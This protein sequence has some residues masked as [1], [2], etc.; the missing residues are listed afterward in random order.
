MRRLRRS[1]LP[2]LLLWSGVAFGAQ[3]EVEI[4]HDPIDC[5]PVDAF[6][7]VQSS[8][9]PPEDIQTAKFYFRSIEH[10]DYY[11]VELTLGTNGGRAIAPKAEPTTPGVSYY[12]ELVTRSFSAFRTEE[13]NVPVASGSECKRRDPGAAFYTGQNPDIAVGAT[14]LGATPLPPGFQ[15][16]GIARFLSA[17][18][19]SGEAGGGGGV[20]GK[21]LG[22]IAGIGGAGA[23]ALAL[24][25]GGSSETT[26]T[27]I[28]GVTTSSVSSTSTST[29]IGGVTS[30]T[31][32]AGG[33]GSSTS[34]ATT[35]VGGG[36]STTTSIPTTGPS[37]T[38]TTSPTTGPTTSP[39][40][41]PSTTPSTSPSTNPSTN[42]TTSPS[43]NP[44]T[45]PTT[46]PSTVDVTVSISDGGGSKKVG[47]VFPY[48]V[49]VTN[50]G[51]G[52]ASGVTVTISRSPASLLSFTG[53]SSGASCSALGATLVQCVFPNV[54]AGQ[55]K[56]ARV[57]F[58]ALQAGTVTVGASVTSSNEPAANQGNNTGS[59]STPITAALQDAVSDLE[60]AFRS[61][62]DLTRP[63][64]GALARILVNDS[65]V[66][67]N[68]GSV[69]IHKMKGRPGE[70]RVEVVL[71]NQDSHGYLRFDFSGS[72]LFV[73]GSLRIGSGDVESVE[74]SSVR[75]V[76]RPGMG[77][78]RFTFLLDDPRGTATTR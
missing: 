48:T 6:L 13:R 60:L 52:T 62:L 8:F 31:T 41:S 21:T 19:I 2:W 4:V 3:G 77:P 44:S 26:T 75:F 72:T 30:T 11:Y 24:S 27:A 23:A 20:S 14:R 10:L 64:R 40:T 39:T 70:N 59:D 57:S 51:S 47:Q 61:A 78:L 69:Q 37:T 18:G 46:A 16:D 5:W 7:L 36:G 9:V 33:G 22:I 17:T 35:T 1:A 42:P 43:T 73:P 28:G 68:G 25:G 54:P 56:T 12:L 65:M 38:P 53:G 71:V 32:T 50:I 49:V 74:G 66:G 67:E 55:P 15:A 76:V 34:S 45:T 58:Q 63:G 29:A